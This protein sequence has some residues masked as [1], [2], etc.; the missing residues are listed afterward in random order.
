MDLQ[1][2]IHD[3]GIDPA[4][5]FS[6]PSNQTPSDNAAAESLL[7]DHVI[8]GRV[9][10]VADGDTVT[11]LDQNNQQH[12]I[13]LAAIDTPERGQPFGQAA[14]DAIG[15]L[16]YNRFVT[17]RVQESDRYGRLIGWINADGQSINHRLVRDG[18]AWHY[19]QYDKSAALDELENEARANRR[20]LWNDP[21]PIPPWEWRKPRLE[22]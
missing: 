13:R 1:D 14:R 3:S 20:G 9:I 6:L 5:S 18:M 4:G 21:N 12:K 17:V 22:A 11:V 16:C 15:T 2:L 7:Q 19:R 8:T 10:A